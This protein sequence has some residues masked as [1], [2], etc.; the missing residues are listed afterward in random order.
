M[1]M[2]VTTRRRKTRRYDMETRPILYVQR[3]FGGGTNVWRFSLTISS[4]YMFAEVC[5]DKKGPSTVATK[6]LPPTTPYR[7]K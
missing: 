1:H 2:G 4:E 5:G 7:L 6:K 3:S